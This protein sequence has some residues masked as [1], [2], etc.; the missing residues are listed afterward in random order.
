[1]EF[2]HAE[3][4]SQEQ[5]DELKMMG[6][7]CINHLLIEVP[8]DVIVLAKLTMKPDD[9]EFDNMMKFSGSMD[10]SNLR[11]TNS[12]RIIVILQKSKSEEKENT[13]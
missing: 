3:V 9:P 12:T 4:K 10:I 7:L 13:V 1:M 8:D 11:V 5:L 6:Y 2:D